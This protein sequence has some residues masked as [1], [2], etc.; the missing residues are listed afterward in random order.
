[1]PTKVTDIGMRVRLIESA[2]YPDDRGYFSE[3]TNVMHWK[4]FGFEPCAQNLSCNA[5]GVLRGL[6]A[7]VPLQAKLVRCVYGRIV[8]V[9]VDARPGSPTFGQHVMA[10]LDSPTKA[11]FIPQG[12]LHGF[13]SLNNAV[14]EYLVDNPYNER[15]QIG[16]NP[17]DPGLGIIWNKYGEAYGR[18][19]GQMILSEKDRRAPMFNACSFG[20][21]DDDLLD[22]LD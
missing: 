17:L 4:E 15:R 21:V 22:D 9:A 1:M 6:H 8:D 3:L 19:P 7:Q 14:V 12:F 13:L 5:P 11:L 18:G 10:L 20:E 2:Y 16:V